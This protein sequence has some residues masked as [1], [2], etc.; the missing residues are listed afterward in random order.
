MGVVGMPFIILRMS[1]QI[2]GSIGDKYNVMYI[3]YPYNKSDRILRL[4][5]NG[6]IMGT[7]SLFR[8]RSFLTTGLSRRRQKRITHIRELHVN[9]M[10]KNPIESYASCISIIFCILL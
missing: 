4:A 6:H 5:P 10:C 7:S 8:S 1:A 3:L 9:Y 2:F